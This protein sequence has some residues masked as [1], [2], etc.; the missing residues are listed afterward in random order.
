MYAL[1]AMLVVLAAVFY[2]LA[3]GRKDIAKINA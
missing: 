1:L 2:H 3:H